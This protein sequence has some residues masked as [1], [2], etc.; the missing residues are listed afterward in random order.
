MKIE[1]LDYNTRRQ[2]LQLP[3]YGREIQKMVEHAMKLEDREERQICA[4]NIVSTMQR[5]FPLSGD[6]ENDTHKFWDHLAIMSDFKLDIDY[7]FDVDMSKSILAK[8]N[9]MQYTK[10]NIKVRHY[11]SLMSEIFDKLK[12]MP[13]GE[14]RDRLVEITANHMKYCL[15]EYSQGSV[16]D[17]KV[18]DDLAYYTDGKIQLDLN[19][20]RFANITSN[21]TPTERKKKNVRQ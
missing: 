5:I 2:K 16:D 8:P 15:I 6:R 10:N 21:R 17:Q 13:E 7:P 4:E 11:G 12:E 19:R 9:A 1:G 3:E 14:E 20:F 18:A